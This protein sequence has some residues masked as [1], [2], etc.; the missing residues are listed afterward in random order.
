MLEFVRAIETGSR[1]LSA[2]IEVF[3]S[4]DYPLPLYSPVYRNRVKMSM[5]KY[6]IY[7]GG[8]TLLCQS[9]STSINPFRMAYFINSGRVV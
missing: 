9:S 4:L 3:E 5:G 7:A 2:E 8:K 6:P 1:V